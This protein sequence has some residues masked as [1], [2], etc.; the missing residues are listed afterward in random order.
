MVEISGQRRQS[1][2]TSW[3]QAA[4]LACCG[5]QGMLESCEEHCTMGVDTGTDLHVVISH[6]IDHA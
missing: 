1:Q 3:D 6:W 4:V 2:E 5:E